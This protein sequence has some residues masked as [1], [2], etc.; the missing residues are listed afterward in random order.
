[1]TAELERTG[2]V[3]E[4]LS[5]VVQQHFSCTHVHMSYNRLGAQSLLLLKTL[6]SWILDLQGASSFGASV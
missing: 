6:R 3:T 2:E 5:A 4:M 1:M